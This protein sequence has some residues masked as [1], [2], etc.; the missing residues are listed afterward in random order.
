M[1]KPKGDERDEAETERLREEVVRRM[2]N[3]PPLGKGG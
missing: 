3:T 2:V 1:T